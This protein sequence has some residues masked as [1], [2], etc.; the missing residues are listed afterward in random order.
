MDKAMISNRFKT[1]AREECKGSCDLYEQL[2][3]KIAEDDYILDICMH[4]RPGQPIPNL[5][6]G[7]VHFLLLQD[8][9]HKLKTFYGSIVSSPN[10]P[11][12]SFLYF[13]EFCTKYS[14]TII[15]LLNNKFV[16]TNEVRR[17]SY[18]YPCFCFISEKAQKPLALIELG[19]SAGLQLL[20]D[21]YGY[22]YGND[23]IYG[24][25]EADV[26][27]K[28]AITGR[29]SLHSKSPT[30]VSRTGIDLHINDLNNPEDYLWLMSLIW[31]SHHERRKLFEAAAKEVR[32]NHLDMIEGDGVQLIPEIVN[33]IPQN[34]AICIFHTHVA[35]QLSR[36]E[37]SKLLENIR[38]IGRQRDVFHL[39][40]N[41]QD[42]YL[43]LDYYLNGCEHT[44]TIGKTDGHGSWFSWEMA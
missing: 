7:A 1:F 21:K 41:I 36:D 11:G 23:T 39:Y 35:N 40:N 8:P 15:S 6:F 44:H 10:D 42:R 2:S 16:Q 13:R 19:T 30:V 12:D 20:W 5:L 32:K 38:Q 33:G 22:S 26:Y 3:M 29:P 17:C 4:A 28:R 34:A 14:D 25:P 27:V 43:H 24:N 37:Q 9:N 31:P 18:L